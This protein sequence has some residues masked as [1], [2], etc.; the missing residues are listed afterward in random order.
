[1]SWL[2]RYRF[3]LYLRHSI[4]IFPALSMVMGLIAV[5]LLHRIERA[6]GWEL[7]VSQETAR[8]VMSTV[9]TSMFTLVVVGTSAVLLV[10]QLASAQLTPRIIALVYRDKLRKLSLSVFV[11]TFTFSVGVL[12][13][14]ESRVPL[15]T[16]YIAAYG[17]LINLALFLH[18][19]DSIGKAV[20]PS[21][22]LRFLGLAG[23]E[24]IQ[25]LYPSKLKRHHPAM[26]TPIEVLDREPSRVVVNEVDGVVLAFDRRGLVA[27][28]R[29]AN[30]LIELVPEVGDFVAAGDPLFRIFDG[31][32]SIPVERLH[33][34]VAL[35]QERTLEQ[36]PMYAFR[37]IVDIASKALSPAINDP[38]TAVLAIDQ[39]HHLLR[40]VGSRN[41]AE[42]H[43]KDRT[44]QVRLVYRT[45]DWDDFVHLAVTEIRQYGRES[46]QI[47]R[48]LRAMLEN[49]ILTLP[50]QR[51]P[52]LQLELNL[53]GSSSKRMFP[54]LDDQVLAKTGDLQGM[55]GGDKRRERN[56]SFIA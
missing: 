5:T 33:K 19:V 36:D 28:A 56:V 10:V 43:I 48:R 7:T 24:V 27:L 40:A 53:L 49:L 32:Q 14:M 51:G 11:F 20:R 54:D 13:R 26:E 42:G 55:G 46:I 38:T 34:S 39:I 17:F 47:M 22:A 29:N 23:R 31:G 9:A 25:G 52:L 1:M 35:G 8:L 18:F 37:V 41:L 21:S 30:C 3:R 44:G 12:V 4:W 6:M 50:S 16:S 15:L 45:P 2:D